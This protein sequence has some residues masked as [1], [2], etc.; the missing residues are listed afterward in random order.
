MA[1]RNYLVGEVAED[2][3][4]GLLSRREAL[5]RLTLL[6]LQCEQCDCLAGRLRRPTGGGSGAPSPAAD[7]PAP[8]PVT[9]TPGRTAT[10][11]AGEAVRFPG[12]AGELQGGGGAREDPQGALLVIHENRGLTRTSSTSWGMPAPQ[13]GCGYLLS[14]QVCTGAQDP[15]AA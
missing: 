1:L 14:A 8:A 9:T 7:T 3:V 12:P 15:A 13:Q 5:R 6:G 10:T 11:K 2:F 4:D